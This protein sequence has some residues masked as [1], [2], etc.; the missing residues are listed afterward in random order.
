MRC[1]QSARRSCTVT[2]LAGLNLAVTTVLLLIAQAVF[3]EPM[4]GSDQF[5]T[6]AGRFEDNADGTVT[7]TRSHLMWMRCSRGQQWID[8]RCAGQALRLSWQAAK[9]FA[10]DVNQQGQMFYNDWRVPKVSEL[11]TIAELQCASPRINVSVFP[12]TVPSWYWTAS[13]RPNSAG[14]ALALSF[15]TEGVGHDDLTQSALVRLVR[16]AQ[17]FRESRAGR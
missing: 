3:A 14:E 11:A 16:S 2:K 12:D 17:G 7:D 1:S 10:E 9:E 8:K 15:G 13:L 5:A 4:C 6:G